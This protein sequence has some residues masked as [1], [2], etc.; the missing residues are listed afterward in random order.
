MTNKAPTLH[1]KQLALDSRQEEDGSGHSLKHKQQVQQAIANL[2]RDI[3]RGTHLTAPEVF[4]RA[5]EGGLQVSLSTV[6]RTLNQL[7]AHGDVASLSG[8]S[9]RRYEHA[10]EDHDHLICLRCGLTIEFVDDLIRGF[11]K[12]VAQRKGFEHK[13]SR[14]DI[15]GLC[16]ECKDTDESHRINS[17]LQSLRSTMESA[18]EAID[19]CRQAMTVLESRR[20]PRGASAAKAAH[21]QL[22][23]SIKQCQESMSFLSDDKVHLRDNNSSN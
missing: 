13:S 16:K 21:N 10:T 8:G 14:F 1:R 7:H 2:V 18:E 11:G 20:I 15:L 5:Q 9:G 4:R 6:Y 17:A 19:L 12:S 22:L 23:D 3:P